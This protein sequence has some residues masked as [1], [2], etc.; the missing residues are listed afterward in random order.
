MICLAFEFTSDRRSVAVADGETVLAEV[1]HSLERRTPVFALIDRALTEAGVAREAVRRLAVSIGPGSYTGVRIAI[2]AA[3]GWHLATGAEVVPVD[4]FE[5]LR[6]AA[7]E[8][9]IPLP[10]TFAVDAQRNEFAVRTWTGTGWDGPMKLEAMPQILERLAGGQNV[11]GPDLGRLIRSA[12]KPVPVVDDRAGS[13]GLFPNASVVA[14]MACRLQ[15]VPTET[16]APVY[17]REAAFVKAPP[18]RV[19][20]GITD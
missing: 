6:L 7:K 20:A 12:T 10:T 15:L 19:I 14:R 3:Q 5:V 1:V 17:L 8:C 18:A 16:L 4:T 2:S 11:V 9:S 13:T